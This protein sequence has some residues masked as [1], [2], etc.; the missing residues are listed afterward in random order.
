MK[1]LTAEELRA[2]QVNQPEMTEFIQV[3]NSILF[4]NINEQ[5]Q[6]TLFRVDGLQ[7]DTIS[8]L[9]DLGYGVHRY[10]IQQ[11]IKHNE[12]EHSFQ[13]ANL[14]VYIITW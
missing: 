5:R 6:A 12:K 7:L 11:T 1:H 9:K 8:K 13:H 4:N 2:A 10:T 3:Y 14:Y